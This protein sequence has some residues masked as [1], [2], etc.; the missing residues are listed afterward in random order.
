MTLGEVIQQIRKAHGLSK[1]EGARKIGVS[2]TTIRAW[3][4]EGVIPDRDNAAKFEANMDLT[5]EERRMFADALAAAT[6]GSA[7]L[8]TTPPTPQQPTPASPGR[9]PSSSGRQGRPPVV[10]P[11]D[12]AAMSNALTGAFDP[13][14]HDLWDATEVLNALVEAGAAFRGLEHSA[15]AARA[16][17]DAAA[18]LR[19]RGVPISAAAL[20][21]VLP[22]VTSSREPSATLPPRGKGKT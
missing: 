14:T 19:V 5:E 22:E 6:P 17:L 13:R 10:S 3:E 20:A 4:T 21:V 1:A 9:S 15:V 7:V 12:R 16:W 18:L 2:W 8:S 11:V